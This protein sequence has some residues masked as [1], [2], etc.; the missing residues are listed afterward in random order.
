MQLYN[1]ESKTKELFKPLHEQQVT[2]YCCGPTVYNYA[3]IGNLRTYIFMDLLRR[4]LK[5]E[6]YKIKDVKVN[7]DLTGYATETYVG[8]AIGEALDSYEPDLTGYATETYVG[9]TINEALNNYEVDFTG[10]AT[11]AYVGT[12]IGLAIT[13]AFNGIKMAEEGAY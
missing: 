10:Y 7:V 4:A 11:E 8:T 5:Y 13:Q 9:T 1:T 2:M 3:H 12:A 6:G